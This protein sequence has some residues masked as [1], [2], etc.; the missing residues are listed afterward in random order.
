MTEKVI[1]TQA[2]LKQRPVGFANLIFMQVC[3]HKDAT[4]NE[5]LE[6]CNLENPAGT[7]NGWSAVRHEDDSQWGATAPV[8]CADDPTRT[9]YLVSC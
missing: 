3:A 6:V 9:H 5:I 2:M 8:Q 7:E 1:V 4:D